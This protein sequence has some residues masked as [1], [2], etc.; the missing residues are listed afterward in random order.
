MT[1]WTEDKIMRLKELHAEGYSATR[2]ALLLGCS[3]NTISGKAHRLGFSFASIKTAYVD[4]PSKRTGP[5][6]PVEEHMPG[7]GCTLLELTRHTCRWPHGNPGSPDFKFCAA[8][9][10]D[11]TPYCKHHTFKASWRSDDAYIQRT[12]G[13]SA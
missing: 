11:E 12:Q 5:T 10:D 3:R 8:W 2:I 4:R 7:P 9:C 13:T 1:F 6:H